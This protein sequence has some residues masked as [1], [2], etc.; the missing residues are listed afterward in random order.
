MRPSMIV[1]GG[2]GSGSYA[3]ED[4]RFGELLSALGEGM[5]AM[6]RGSSLDG[7][8]AA[9]GYLE[10]SGYFNAGRGA[11]LTAEGKVELDAAVMTGEE[12]RGA[13]VGL[14]HCTYHP[15]SLARWVSENTNHVLVAGEKCALYARAAGLEV[16]EVSPSEA[17]LSKFKLLINES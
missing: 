12:R 14:V 3:E 13:G 6:R 15:V 17:A 1:H 16:E 2:A 11:C 4:N 7:V 5:A 8:E 9:V 10:G